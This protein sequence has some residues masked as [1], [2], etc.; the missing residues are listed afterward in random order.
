MGGFYLQWKYPNTS[1]RLTRLLF[2]C[3]IVYLPIYFLFLAR[4]KQII[5]AKDLQLVTGSLSQIAINEST[6]ESF[7]T[8]TLEE[9]QA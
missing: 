8:I 2:I 9:W 7:A 6:E 3:L 4:P 5:D 1:R